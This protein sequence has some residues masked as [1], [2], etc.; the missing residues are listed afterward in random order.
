M[1]NDGAPH[2]HRSK[3]TNLLLLVTFVLISDGAALIVPSPSLKAQRHSVLTRNVNVATSFVQSSDDS[4]NKGGSKRK[5]SRPERKAL[6]RA[7][8]H[9]KN[10]KRN[11][12][13]ETPQYKLRSQKISSLSKDTSTADDV[14]QA[15]KRAQNLHDADDLAVIE[16]FLL[17][18]VDETFAFG[19]LGSLFSRLAVAAMH[20]HNRELARKA[21][22]RRRVEFRSSW[23][24][25]ESAAI[26]R[27]LLRM[28]NVTDA[29]EVLNDEL[30]LPLEVCMCG[31]WEHAHVAHLFTQLNSH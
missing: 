25:M 2:S 19:Y 6:E 11:R 17:Y 24:P 5:L 15:I 4:H 14:F 27:G 26:I 20:M 7:H 28:H 21:L 10:C 13:K 31:G 23:L 12:E 22:E 1:R 8:K 18:E 30:C 3:A 16:N 9:Q 29:L